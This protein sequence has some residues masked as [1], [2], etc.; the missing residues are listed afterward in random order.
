MSETIAITL[1]RHTARGDGSYASTEHGH[2][3][4]GERRVLDRTAALLLMQDFPG[5]FA[6]E[7]SAPDGETRKPAPKKR[8]TYTRKPKA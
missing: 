1:I 4:R 3:T 7:S 5:C 8:R 6:V 2:W